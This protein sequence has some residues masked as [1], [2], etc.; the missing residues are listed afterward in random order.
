MSRPSWMSRR[1]SCSRWLGCGLALLAL[2]DSVATSQPR[3]RLRASGVLNGRATVPLVTLPAEWLYLDPDGARREPLVTEAA[4]YVPLR[5]GKV[6]AL[7]RQDGTRLWETSPGVATAGTLYRLGDRLVACATRPPADGDAATGVVRLLDLATGVVQREISLPRPITSNLVSDG[8]RL[9]ARLG[10]TEVAALDPGDFSI[11]WRVSGDFTEH[12]TC[13][14]DGLLAGL[15]AG[16][17]WSLRAADGARQWACELGAQPGP[18]AGDAE[19]VY[20]GTAQGDAVAIR[21]ADG[22]IRWRRRTGGAIAAPPLIDRGR[23]LFA[24]YDN[25]LYAFDG[26]RGE[27]QWRQ[28]MAGR[29]TAPPTPLTETTLAVAALDDGEITIVSR[30]DGRIV[31]RWQLADERLFSALCRAP[32]LLIAATERGIAAVKL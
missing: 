32:G 26:A 3:P 27:M 5:S 19:R 18:A 21:R 14:G 6:V 20:C 1:L 11:L 9:Y 7:A 25:F 16:A 15:T 31:A 23:A 29:L 10:A 30:L 13:D 24:S 12:L 2:G 8:V 17:L 28:Q 4:V 22:R